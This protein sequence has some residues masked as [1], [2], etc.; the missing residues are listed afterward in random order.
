M[1]ASG[2]ER[3]LQPIGNHCLGTKFIDASHL[4]DP[5]L[6]AVFDEIASGIEG[7]NYGRF[8]LKV[9]DLDALKRGEEIMV[10]ELNG[11]TSE[12]GHTL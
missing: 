1:P 10:P 3:L 4:I 12:P 11:V 6:V 7:F 2:E 8:D 5:N 9:K